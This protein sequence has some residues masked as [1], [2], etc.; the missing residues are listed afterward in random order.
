MK[1]RKPREP[2]RTGTLPRGRRFRSGR[3]AAHAALWLF[4]ALSIYPFFY[5]LVMSLKSNIQIIREFWAIFPEPRHWEN[6]GR[7]WT[8]IRRAFP[9]SILITTASCAGVLTLGCVSGYVFA[10]HRFRGKEILYYA[11][12]SLMMVPGILTLVPG[13]MLVSKLRLV[14]TYWGAILPYIA[15]GQVMA[16]FMFRSYFAS[17]PE[18]LFEA[19]RLDGAGELRILASLAVP[20]SKPMMGTVAIL[21]VLGTWNDIIWPLLVLSLKDHRP[22]TVALLYFSRGYRVEEGPLMA[23]NVLA[24]IPI[25]LLFLG[26]MHLFIQGI[27]SGGLKA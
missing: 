21:T 4:I 13:Y 12:V 17:L 8:E 15:G 2:N 9:N 11:V 6:Y 5:M 26:T 18:D 3:I 22:L 14:N 20:L 27:T 1:P 25:M 10:R 19:A 24:S 16:V 7:A 23:G